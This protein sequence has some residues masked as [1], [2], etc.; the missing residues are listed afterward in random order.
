MNQVA[1][2]L[3]LVGAAAVRVVALPSTLPAKWDL[4]DQV[5]EGVDL[6]AL[7]DAA[8][9]V[10]SGDHEPAMPDAAEETPHV[11]L[12]P[13]VV[14]ADELMVLEVTAR[15]MIVDP[16]IPS[17]SLSMIFGPRGAGK[18]WVS[19]SLAMAIANGENFLAYAVG[20]PRVVLFID[21][22]MALA[23]LQDRVRKLSPTPPPNLLILPSERLFQAARPINLHSPDDQQAILDLLDVLEREGCRPEVIIFDNL[24]SLS[25]GV[26]ENDNSA[27]DQLLRWLI[28][29]RHTGMAVILVHHAGKNGTQR[30]A[31]RREDLLETVIALMPPP[32]DASPHEGAHLILT[33]PKTRGRKPMPDSLELRLTEN[34][35]RLEW[36]FT[37]SVQVDR[38]TEILRLAWQHKPKTQAELAALAKVKEAAISHQV[39]KLRLEGYL[40]DG[41]PPTLTSAGRERLL[42]CWPELY[43]AMSQQSDLPIRSV[44]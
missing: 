4:A 22:E 40:E 17:S 41:S 44:I 26:D 28:G 5:P 34:R 3:A 16:F 7:L 14:G 8:V 23:D 38:A 36:Q 30:G 39:K 18:T 35:G 6:A 42:E 33:F 29:L 12:R 37:N 11:G 13:L 27:L 15:E 24:S 19:M 2:R 43:D 9:L 25:G 31:S 32:E 1:Q 10:R 20:E 21:G